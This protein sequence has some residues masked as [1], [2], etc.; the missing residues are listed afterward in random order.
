MIK[1][2][3][4]VVFVTHSLSEINVLFPIFSSLGVNSNIEITI[5]FTVK[6]IHKD[7]KKSAFYNHCEKRL[8]ITTNL[9]YIPNKFDFKENKK[10]LFIFG[11]V[12]KRLNYLFWLFIALSKL[13]LKIMFSSILMH[14]FSNQKN[15]TKVLYLIHFIFKK[16]IL[17]YHHGNEI[18]TDKVS[19]GKR[20]KSDENTILLFAAHNSDY[21]KSL[22]Y[23]NQFLMGYPIFFKEW[24]ELVND[25]AK[26]LKF[27]NQTVLIYSR[28][29][30]ERY[31]DIDKYTEL[32]SSSLRAIRS[33]F[34]DIEIVIKP[35]PRE[36]IELIKKILEIHSIAN[37]SI[38]YEHPAV[39]AQT[40]RMAITFW[41]SVILESLSM[42][43]PTVEYYI[44][45]DKF[46]E[47]YPNG[48]NYKAIGI[49][50]V[51]QESDLKIFMDSVINNS[52][53]LPLIIN[54]FNDLKNINIFKN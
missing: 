34:N 44:E 16:K 5:I 24:K 52:Y 28:H 43:V 11:K 21:M 3:K 37:V 45:A 36:D 25:Y 2:K 14:E 32:L 48:S 51:S 49:D 10:D 41:G 30:N 23:H 7:Y 15:A 8:K 29:V 31:M 6:K 26:K 12:M 18:T 47:D 19:T 13:F 39:L 20:A 38:S 50:S 22:G 1:T 33:K 17:T 35:H 27:Q 9:C 53:K 4:I 40:A 42:G 54:E 46:R